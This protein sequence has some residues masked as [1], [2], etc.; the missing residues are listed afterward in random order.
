MSATVRI[1]GMSLVLALVACGGG[2]TN[3][4]VT[5]VPPVVGTAVITAANAPVITGDVL[6]AAFESGELGELVGTGGGGAPP[7]LG[8]MLNASVSPEVRLFPFPV[9]LYD[10][11]LFPFPVILY[12]ISLGPVTTLCALGGSVTLS[13]EIGDPL[14]LSSGDRINFDFD[15]CDEGNGSVVDGGFEFLV[16]S[17]QGDIADGFDPAVSLSLMNLSVTEGG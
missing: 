16:D 5:P 8:F 6:D 3:G 17:F 14:T 4:T 11:P 15:M 12:N 1:L 13:G 7:T 9:I 10:I 2:G